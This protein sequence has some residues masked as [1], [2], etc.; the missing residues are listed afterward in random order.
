VKIRTTALFLLYSYFQ[1]RLGTGL[2]PL[3]FVIPGLVAHL[4]RIAVCRVAR[5]IAV[6]GDPDIGALLAPA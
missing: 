3:V 5:D 4:R 6:V 1:P 2:I